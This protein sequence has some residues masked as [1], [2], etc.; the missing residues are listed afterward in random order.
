METGDAARE[1][2]YGEDDRDEQELYDFDLLPTLLED[3]ENVSLADI[4][5]LRDSSLSEQDIWA[6]CLE[7]IHSLKSISHSAIFQTLCITPDTLAFNNNGNVC[8][9]EQL[10]DDPEG[11]FVSPEFDIT[12]NTYEA[13]IYSLG[14]TLKAASEFVIEPE[15]EPNFC[16]ELKSLLE[17]M[18]Q[19]N[20]SDRPDIEIIRSL[21][22]DK[23]KC[24]SCS[25]CRRLSAVGRRVLSIE[26][27]NVFQVDECENTWKGR[28]YQASTG[29]KSWTDEKIGSIPFAAEDYASK[30][31][32][33]GCVNRLPL[34]DGKRKYGLNEIAIKMCNE[35]IPQHSKFTNYC[36]EKQ[37]AS[38][39][40]NHNDCVLETGPCDHDCD[41][42]PRKSLISKP[43][44]FPKNSRKYT[45]EGSSLTSVF[46]SDK[47][48][49]TKKGWPSASD[50]P[51]LDG[52]NDDD[53]DNSCFQTESQPK[54]CLVTEKVPSVPKRRPEFCSD[55]GMDAFSLAFPET[56]LV[57]VTCKG[58]DHLL[59]G[60]E[61]LGKDCTSPG[62]CAQTSIF[63]K[64]DYL[65]QNNCESSLLKTNSKGKECKASLSN[66][67]KLSSSGLSRS[68]AKNFFDG[69][70]ESELI[71]DHEQWISLKDLLSQYGRPLKEFE[72]WALCHECLHALQ[73]CINYPVYLSLDTVMID[74]SGKVLYSISEDAECYD[75]FCL[76]PEFEEKGL[77]TEKVCVYGVAAILWTAAKYNFLPDHRL[78]LPKKL[79]RL[80]LSMAKRNAN[81][82]P[83]VADAL[84]ICKEYLFQQGIKSNKVWSQLSRC[85]YQKAHENE[86]AVLLECV[87]L[88]LANAHNK[89]RSMDPTIGFV[90][91]TN[92]RITAVKG[93]VPCQ[94]SLRNEVSTLP[95]TFTSPATYFKPII[96]M[97][98]T[99]FRRNQQEAPRISSSEQIVDIVNNEIQVNSKE[100]ISVTE[101]KSHTV[102]E[103][104]EATHLS[105]PQKETPT[106]NP[107][108]NSFISSLKRQTPNNVLSFTA[109]SAS[110]S[111][112]L[113]D[114]K[115]IIS[116]ASP[117]SSSVCS[118][119][120]NTPPL[121]NFLLKQD[122]T[123]GVQK[124]PEKMQSVHFHTESACE[125]L[126]NLPEFLSCSLQNSNSGISFKDNSSCKQITGS[127]PGRQENG[128][129]NIIISQNESLDA[130]SS[131]DATNNHVEMNS[132]EAEVCKEGLDIAISFPEE[133]SSMNANSDL[134]PALQPKRTICSYVQKVVQL[135]Q[136]EFAFDGYLENGVED[137][138][139]GEYIFA[140]KGLQFGT[141]CGAIS[142]KFCDLYWDETLLE[143]LYTVVNGE[144]LSPV[145][146]RISK[147]I[148]T[149]INT[150]E[151]FKRNNTSPSRKKPRKTKKI[152]KQSNCTQ[153][154]L[155]QH[156]ESVCYTSLMPDMPFQ[157]D[158]SLETFN[159]N[160]GKETLVT[161][162]TEIPPTIDS[163]SEDMNF[164]KLLPV[165]FEKK[166]SPQNPLLR[167]ETK[168]HS[169]KWNLLQADS[170]SLRP[171]FKTV[172][173][174]N[175]ED[176]FYN[177]ADVYICN[178]GWRSAFYGAQ[179]FHLDV[180]S[181][182]HKLGLQK[183]NETPNIMAKKLE[184]QQQLTIET[185]NY[186]KTVQFY[187]KLLQKERRNKE[188]RSIMIKL[189]S[190]LEEMKSKV[191]FLELVKKYLQA[192]DAE[193]W[194]LEQ[195]AL[196]IVIN[197][198]TQCKTE[199]RH[200]EEKSLLSFYSVREHK[201]DKPN[202]SKILQAGTPLGLM[203]YLYTR[204]AFLEGYVQQFLYTFR[205]FCA[206]KDFLQFLI[207]RAKSSLSSE[208]VTS[209]TTLAKIYNR[210]FCLL[211]TWIEDCCTVDF[212][213]NPDL[214]DMLETFIYSTLIP[215]DNRGEQLLSSLQDTGSRKNEF[216]E[217]TR[218]LHSLCTKFSEDNI[219]RKS[220][221]WTHS[222]GNEAL[223]LHQK[224][225]IVSALPRP[226]YP[227]FI[228]GFS[229]S[230][231]KVCERDSY[232]INE[233]SVQQLS[234]Q[235]TLLQ[236]KI[237]QKCH[238]VHF[239]NSRV[240]GVKDRATTASKIVHSEAL[241]AE[242]C[243][244]F[245]QDCIQDNYLI[246]ILR[247]EDNV[248]TWVAAEIVT[249]HTSKLQANL[250]LKFLL[251]AKCCYKQRNF[252]TA[253]QILRG[254][255]NLIVRQ[256][257]VWKNLPSKVSEMMKDLKAVEVFLK[258]ES[259]CLMKGDKFKTLPTIPSA[260]LL[261]MHIQQLETGGFTMVNGTYKWT[262]LRNIA[263]VVSQIRA[264]QEI[265]Y[266]LTPDP[267]LQ[268]YLEKRFAH[269]SEA[270]ISA[271]AAENN[272]NY[273]PMPAEKHSRRIQDTLR[274]MKATFQ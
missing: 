144:T 53:F 230:Y 184:L 195:C 134:E 157:T 48:K 84:Q 243:S 4:L 213:A 203:A 221:K 161:A 208:N 111:N 199:Y 1:E 113:S 205:Y 168:E 63:L 260:H 158:G 73:T 182:A 129:T 86:S 244:L 98:N 103:H 257:P 130:G 65:S 83:S 33:I 193:Q 259:L 151:N 28:E 274:R 21:C 15:L 22:E 106:A 177:T 251:I 140:L 217:D 166:Y 169:K 19:E 14:A 272:T 41:R 105:P 61:V 72:L 136:E 143:N 57:R 201:G 26:S 238:P 97:Q 162:Y 202:K 145:G 12:G 55:C 269:F 75:A 167:I 245:V 54:L 133:S 231:M 76:A 150:S 185:K 29:V 173:E 66:S 11:A 240:L 60:T 34:D 249:S 3:E 2:D 247:Y 128:I 263:K 24:S 20:P 242:V 74:F 215:K 68:G 233:Y 56:P 131:F 192:S 164:Q 228:E 85:A 99:D 175:T 268:Y 5:S 262:K 172:N 94:S 79:K 71:N 18:Q 30:S 271:L 137:L 174:E 191:Q 10:G 47:G 219:S 267:E 67:S 27:I 23:M 188:V 226:C 52:S 89:E 87:S 9:R 13:H 138:A 6:V 93:P 46:A 147:D 50:L 237:F 206:Q 135:I 116:V 183:E 81:E 115:E 45:E 148:S 200:F 258:S 198:T 211:Q 101:M 70:R 210:T 141:F 117:S 88:K 153:L 179:C 250:L 31:C 241:P 17:Q 265:P 266:A 39:L 225:N 186:K 125:C 248:S 256:L 49:L 204:N 139:M 38:F 37:M 92:K 123:T 178:P 96:L 112:H 126:G 212:T 95:T 253:M 220:F 108:S 127:T 171:D 252:A 255:E 159:L 216:D 155:V 146:F 196:P 120:H 156:E 149:V 218:S 36:D 102:E 222:K 59:A 176:M 154:H 114:Q 124:L 261:A 7:C 207:E 40:Q 190:Q 44:S 107:T 239:L 197:M 121:H 62:D 181:Y 25:I 43:Q 16:Q 142:E 8:F 180:Q 232:F 90:P 264:F 118:T 32:L 100:S 119:L 223:V 35:R 189:K 82:R 163:Q 132:K 91:I 152:E 227:R 77:V 194:G 234:N 224:Y 69:T 187:Q 209:S 214:L 58:P 165:S 270:D 229:G 110:A 64:G 160:P 246:Q 42:L 109:F 235:L 51:L 236:E 78:S 122:P 254:L 80:L 104:S 170:F 273:Y